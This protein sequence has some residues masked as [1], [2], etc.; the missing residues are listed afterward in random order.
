M[1]QQTVQKAGK[2]AAAEAEAK[3]WTSQIV[4]VVCNWCTYTGADMAGTTRRTYPANVRML[5]VPCSGRVNPLFIMK[6]FEQGADG[7]LVS[8]CHPG[9]CHYTQGNYYARRRFAV[10]RAL[11]DFLGVDQGRLHFSWVSASEGIKWAKVV[12]DV[13]AAVNKVGPIRVSKK[14]KLPVLPEPGKPPRK[15]GTPADHDAI[16]GHWRA[17][18]GQLLTDKKVATVIG[19]V[20]GP[21][22][23][24]MV[25]AYVE[26]AEDA[27]KLVWNDLCYSNLVNY[28]AGSRKPAGK[29]AVLVKACDARAL[30]TL[31]SEK[32]IDRD[33]V[34]IVGVSCDGAKEESGLALKCYACDGEVAS[35]S[36]YTLT[37]AGAKEGAV[38]SGANRP[39]AADPRDEQIAFLEKLPSAE[40]WAF[41]QDQFDDCLRCHACRGVCPMCYCGSCITEQHRPQWIPTSINEK[42]NAAWNTVR[43]YH[44]TGRCAGCDECT[45]VC[46][47]NIRLDLVNRRLAKEVEDRFGYRAGEDLDGA[48]PL[49]VFKADDPQEFIY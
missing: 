46:P 9:D 44:L 20:P 8:G 28:L 26:S 5:R 23:D 15:S 33:S 10:F 32:Q 2:P 45:R 48:P 18:A 43:A 24:R 41:W 12:E 3:D 40:R 13:T 17:L 6:A 1:T 31:L 42:G 7:V 27:A 29:A 39:T 47:S 19:Y 11:L 36:D 37:P 14:V 49:A 22:P 25:P 35:V 34:T 21:L 38:K 30:V 4:A 16:T